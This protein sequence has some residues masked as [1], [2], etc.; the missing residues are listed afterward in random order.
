MYSFVLYSISLLLPSASVSVS[1]NGWT[2]QELGSLWLENDFHPASQERNK[3]NGYRLL[4]LDGHNS[5]CTFKFCRFAEKNR[6]IIVCLPSHTTHALQPCDVGVFSPLSNSWKTIVNKCSRE[7]IPITKRNF[8]QYYHAARI[9]AFK[10][11]TII[12][13]FAKSGIWPL[14]RTAIPAEA[15]EPAKA[16]TTQAAMPVPASLAPLLEP[17][18]EDLESIQIS[19]TTAT[20]NRPS[21]PTSTGT[22]STLASDA[23]SS[24]RSTRYRI[25]GIP[26]DLRHTAS[27]A[28]LRNQIAQLRAVLGKVKDQLEHD[29]ALKILMEQENQR[30]RQILYHKDASKKKTY[31]SSEPRHMTSTEMLDALALAEWRGS[32]KTMLKEAGATFKKQKRLIELEEKR[33]AADAKRVADDLKRRERE[34]EKRKKDTEK[35]EEKAR[36]ASEKLAEKTRKAIERLEQAEAQKATRAAAKRGRGGRGRGRARGSGRQSQRREREESESSEDD[37]ISNLS[38]NSGDQGAEAIEKPPFD[39]PERPRPRPTYRRHTATANSTQ[40]DESEPMEPAVAQLVAGESSTPNLR[41]NP[42]RKTRD[43]RN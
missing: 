36:K 21:S 13:A 43:Q 25:T 40:A 9:K 10:P 33:L 8:L 7:G 3:T 28:D 37:T 22:S 29:H 38:D 4:I 20:S 31:S 23:S 34:E 17:I 30:L 1:E 35:A 41:R 24:T 42:G 26:P 15:Y 32:W 39:A 27:R 5:H 14:N 6:I 19:A 18:D 2:D 12:S 11:S 16:T